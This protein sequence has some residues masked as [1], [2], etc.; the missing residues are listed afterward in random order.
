LFFWVLLYEVVKY[1]NAKGPSLEEQMRDIFY[2]H[3]EMDHNGIVTGGKGKLFCPREGELGERTVR[4]LIKTPCRD[5]IED[6]RALFCDFYLFVEVAPSLSE[7]SD[8]GDLPVY[9][10][11]RKKGSQVQKATRVREATKELSS[12]E[13]ILGII[14][15]HLSSEWD[16]D[17]DGSLHKTVLRPDSPASKDR[18]KRKA[19][20]RNEDKTTYNKRR[21]GRLPPPSTEPSGDTRWY[22]FASTYSQWDTPW[23]IF[24]QRHVCFDSESIFAFLFSQ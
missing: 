6:L 15:R 13:W 7:D 19:E 17:D 2:Q 16:V 24:T 22:S 18:R 5:I 9:E 21:L 20:D 1:R 10:D 12:S 11:E 23:V 3:T 14:S 8:P 4:K